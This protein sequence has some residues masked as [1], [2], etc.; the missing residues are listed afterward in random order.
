[1]TDAELV[2][3]PTPGSVTDLTLTRERSRTDVNRFLERNHPRGGVTGWRACFAARYEDHLVACVTVERPSSTT[4]P[5][6][7]FYL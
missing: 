3:P 4:H 5:D 2:D 7:C 1:M 6:K